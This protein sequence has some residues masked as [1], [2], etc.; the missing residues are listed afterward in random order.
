MKRPRQLSAAF[1]KTVKQPGRFGDGRGGRGLSLLVKET[2]STDRLSRTWS[3][4]LRINGKPVNIGLGS[5][6]VV[7]LAE[8]REQALENARAVRQGKDPRGGGIPDFQTAAEKVIEI[9]SVRWK[10]G[11]KSEREWH[12]TLASYVYPKIGAKRI[13]QVTSADVLAVLT[14]VWGVKTDTANRVRRRISVVMRWAIA[15]GYR[16][17]DPAG[18][19]VIAAL[20]KP[21]SNREHH[22][23]LHYSKVGEALRTLRDSDARR[24]HVAALEFLA[25][26]ATRS[27]EVCKA[28]WDEIDWEERLWSIDGE[29]TKTGRPLRVPLSSRAMEV[30][31]EAKSKAR[32]SVPRRSLLFPSMTGAAIANGLL[33]KAMKAAGIDAV[34]HGFRSSFRDWCGETGVPREVAELALGHAVGGVEGA[35]ARSDLLDRR[36]PVMENWGRYLAQ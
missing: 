10:K 1:V 19:A 3:Q 29:R 34:P 20:P 15:Q 31:E 26:T 2:V 30:L 7:T 4:R 12:N 35:Y 16:G 18:E 24:G 5:Y 17:D 27:A 9:H 11:G 28:T 36:R 22:K 21:G 33:P 23:A 8:A 14:P 6:P 13:D 32:G 25:L